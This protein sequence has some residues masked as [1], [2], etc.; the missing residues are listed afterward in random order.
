MRIVGF[1]G[2]DSIFIPALKKFAQAYDG[3]VT[4]LFP[5]TVPDENTLKLISELFPEATLHSVSDATKG[6]LHKT[7]NKK[8]VPEIDQVLLIKL[9][10]AERVF[11]QMLDI[12][13]P[14]GSHFTL[15]QKRDLYYSVLRYCLYILENNKP[16]IVLLG[17][18]PHSDYDFLFCKLC[19]LY[20]VK[21]VFLQSIFIPGYVVPYHS[22]NEGNFWLRDAYQ[23]SLSDSSSGTVAFKSVQVE[24]YFKKIQLPYSLGRP[25]H[26]AVF[27]KKKQG[28]L[29]F[30]LKSVLPN[31]FSRGNYARAF[32]YHFLQGIKFA[33]NLSTH[34]IQTFKKYFETELAEP[35]KVSTK[36]YIENKTTLFQWRMVRLKNFLFQKKLKKIYHKISE[37]PDYNKKYVYFPLHYQPE[38]TTYPIG[39]HWID[40]SLPIRMLSSVIPDDWSIYVKEHPCTFSP[41]SNR[42]GFFAR[43]IHY[44][45]NLKKIPKVKIVSIESDSFDL[46]DKA[47]A[48]GTLTGRP[49]WE[50]VNRG[51]PGLVFGSAWYNGCEGVSYIDSKDRCIQAI[52]KITAGFKPDIKKVSLFGKVTVDTQYYFDIY[53]DLPYSGLS[54]SEN[55]DAMARCF[56]NEFAL[57]SKKD[58]TA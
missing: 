55:I 45:E 31:P 12:Y 4:D 28:K 23:K 10:P 14:G 7:W 50:A 48:V 46:I 49:S 33:F 34:P 9:A 30:I 36:P 37:Q 21:Y 58:K 43:D 1:S 52:Q 24:D 22:I 15:L 17:L 6:V 18:M 35:I 32:A 8:K 47:Q 29:K 44:Y 39:L 11:Y 16:D 5:G 27:L 42:G 53:D 20:G 25:D 38:A 57:L 40:L 51:V 26:M 56:I 41:A 54:L 2:S 3:Q 13:D 19:E